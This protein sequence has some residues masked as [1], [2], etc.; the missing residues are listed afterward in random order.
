MPVDPS[1]LAGGFATQGPE[2]QVGGIGG[3]GPAGQPAGPSVGETAPAGEDFGGMLANKIDQL[4]GLQ[5]DAAAASRSLVDGTATDV[6]AVVM[7]V[8]RAKLSMQLASQLRA[9]GTEAYHE[10]FR[11]QV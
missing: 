6:S 1:T 3:L 2:W 7:A 9:K 5:K 11:T 10:I 4:G 8:E